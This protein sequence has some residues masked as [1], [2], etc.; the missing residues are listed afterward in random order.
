VTLVDGFISENCSGGKGT[1]I[2]VSS[3]AEGPSCVER[4]MFFRL[5]MEMTG[6]IVY[7]VD[8]YTRTSW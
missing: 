3:V 2:S 4:T 5:Y 1:S 7:S 6:K 8:S